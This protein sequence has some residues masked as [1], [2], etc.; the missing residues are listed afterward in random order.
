MSV[1]TFN[2]K[3]ASFS[4]LINHIQEIKK[5]MSKSQDLRP[6]TEN[7]A[8][9]GVGGGYNQFGNVPY[10]RVESHSFERLAFQSDIFMISIN[11]LRNRV[12][13]RGFE[14]K[15]LIDQPTEQGELLNSL[16]KRIN[17]NNQSAKDLL[18]VYDQDLNIYDDA[19]LLAI[20][21]Y[22]FD[23]DGEIAGKDTQE[24]IRASPTV[25]AIMSDA[26][27]RLGY[28]REGK[29]IF[30]SVSNRKVVITESQAESLGFR[31]KEGLRLQPAYYKAISY[32]GEDTHEM[33][34]IPGEVLHLSAHNPTMTYGVSPILSIWMKMIT[35]IEQ[36]RFLLLNYQKQ[37]PPRG[38]LSISTTN[39]SSTKK[40][41][42]DMK[43]EAARDPHAINPILLEGKEGS[44]KVE[45]IPLMSPLADMQFTES[46]NEMRRSIMASFG[47]MPLF[48]G[49]MSQAGGLNNE[50]LMPDIPVMIKKNGWIDFVPISS[51]H[52]NGDHKISEFGLKNLQV[53][54]RSGWSPIKRAF[55]HKC[56]DREIFEINTTTGYTEV[57]GDHSLFK[58]NKEDIFGKD[59]NIGEKLE[60][61]R[62]EQEDY[63]SGVTKEFAYTLGLFAADGSSDKDQGG[64]RVTIYNTDKKLLKRAKLGADGFF[65][66]NF[67]ICDY[68]N[69]NGND[70][71]KLNMDKNKVMYWI[72]EYCYSTYSER[73]EWGRDGIKE[74]RM[75]KVPLQIIN[76]HDEIKKSYLEGY[77]DGDGHIDKKERETFSTISKTLCAGL[78]FLYNSL[79]KKTKIEWRENGKSNILRARIVKT[80]FKTKEN[81]VLKVNTKRYTGNVYDIETEDHTF[82]AGV[83]YL[84]HHNSM[85][86]T[87]TNQAVEERQLIYNEKALPW[88]LEQFNITDYTI[89]LQEPEEKDEVIEAKL[90]GVKIDNAVKMSQIG[91]DI[92][93][94][95]ESEQFNYSEEATTPSDQ[96]S[97]F[98]ATN[99]QKGNISKF[100]DLSEEKTKQ[101]LKD[102]VYDMITSEKQIMTDEDNLEFNIEK[103]DDSIIDFITK[104]LYENI[105]KDQTRAISNQ[106]NKIL[107]E[108]VTSKDKI[109]SIQKKIQK[110]GVDKQQAELITRT[111]STILKNSAREFNFK[112]A[113]G[114][115]DFLYRWSGPDDK[116]TA[117][118]SKEI[119]RKSKNGLSLEK[120]KQL[121][122]KTSEKFGFKP[123]R[124][125]YSHPNSRHFFVK[126]FR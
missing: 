74:F 121:V 35:L 92:S 93:Y 80:D 7:Y 78:Q 62:I 26:E 91:F 126:H 101:D 97:P 30:V 32:T 79:G 85:E 100:I 60:I 76:G 22:I 23:L 105:Y 64:S 18:K 107:V 61:K 34:Y 119:K 44:G 58:E 113:T 83:G 14:I 45:W 73:I 29:R 42:E 5:E 54:T 87:V 12:F 116:R 114:S 125:W 11:A 82:V 46:R 66:E 8:M 39:F 56:K 4:K 3:N 96:F 10:Y 106:I 37:R 72:D 69:T 49:D 38:I 111:E 94:D 36:D 27:G 15:Q 50:S 47:V 108:G 57:T 120:L 77:M 70:I 117:L 20:N 19:Y 31:D 28:S 16:M 89:E 67:N 55:R 59:I 6:S 2:N 95:K 90:F 71:S 24:I 124:F 81:E 1:L 118:I 115:E 122:F 48:A 52:K 102:R 75:K 53:L 84:L 112:Q 65:A 98:A 99:L 41:W 110:L 86:I 21:K 63:C 40:S 43:E 88:I 68:K 17:K 123:N 25:M 9:G 33:Y 109:I 103:E 104:Q 13:K 51:L